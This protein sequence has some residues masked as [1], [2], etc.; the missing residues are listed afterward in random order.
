[1]P[2]RRGETLVDLQHLLE[3]LRDAYPGAIEETILTELVANAL[4]AGATRVEFR[5]HPVGSSLVVL[6]DGRGMS[7]SDLREFHNLATSTKVRGRGIGFAGVGV[8]LAL[9]TCREVI[10]ESRR[11]QS[12]A[13]TRW[14]LASRHKAPYEPQPPPGHVAV[15]GT[16]VELRLHNALSPM[17][18][19]GYIEHALRTH[20]APLLDPTFDLALREHYPQGIR[21]DIDGSMVSK[22]G[23]SALER[24]PMAIRIGR[25]RKPS[26]IGFLERHDSPLPEDTRG[27]GISTFGKVIR[28]GWDWLGLAP[29]RSDRVRGLIEVP[30]LSECLT[31]N[32]GDFVRTGTRGSTYLGYRR[33]IQEAVRPKLAEWS[34]TL[35]AAEPVRRRASRPVERDIER[36]VMD[37]AADFPLLS[38][39]VEQRSGGQRKLPFAGAGDDGPPHAERVSVAVESPAALSDPV[40]SSATVGTSTL[41]VEPPAPAPEASRMSGVGG[42][43]APLRRRPARYGLS[44]EFEDRPADPELG[45]LVEST[46]FV[47]SAHPA[48]RRAV[49]SR[50]E[51]YHLALAVAFSLAPLAVGGSHEHAFVTAF[52]ARWGQ[53]VGP[54]KQR[55]DA[56]G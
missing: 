34:E 49:V 2:R 33:A 46:V 26:G 52:L 48:Y 39:L 40:E 16:A 37:L 30:A 20:F 35:D 45:R 15:R 17:L 11:G 55:R 27:V 44:V 5:T 32:K 25:R 23:T 8:K 22:K 50:A 4:D 21:F 18:D 13:A 56:T 42:P 36:V 29:S 28:Y 24:V 47:N 43:E 1:M 10:T 12:H 54:S 6:D 9:L 38:S 31:L 41:N 19:A 7:W 51:G 53:A 14:L 3:D